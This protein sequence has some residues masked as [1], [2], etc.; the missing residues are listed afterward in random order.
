MLSAEFF[1]KAYSD[2]RLP[3]RSIESKAKLTNYNYNYSEGNIADL[4]SNS[5]ENIQNRLSSSPFQCG[6]SSPTS[7]SLP[8]PSSRQRNKVAAA[9]AALNSSSDK[10][11]RN[12]NQLSPP[13]A[14]IRPNKATI[15]S[16]EQDRDRGDDGLRNLAIIVSEAYRHECVN[17][18][19]RRPLTT[20][21]TTKAAAPAPA[22]TREL[23]H[24]KPL[25]NSRANIAT[26]TNRDDRPKTRGKSKQRSKKRISA[27]NSNFTKDRQNIPTKNHNHRHPGNN[28]QDPRFQKQGTTMSPSETAGV[29]AFARPV[30]RLDRQRL[31]SYNHNKYRQSSAEASSPRGVDEITGRELFIK[32]KRPS[33]PNTIMVGGL[34]IQDQLQLQERCDE[35][36]R[37]NRDLKLMV[38]QLEAQIS[39][40]KNGAKKK[41]NDGNRNSSRDM[42]NNII[43]PTYVVDD[44]SDDDDDDS[45]SSPK[46][47]DD[48]AGIIEECL[49]ASTGAAVASPKKKTIK[50]T[51]TTGRTSSSRKNDKTQLAE[52]KTVVQVLIRDLKISRQNELDMRKK[53]QSAR[54]SLQ[55][56]Q[57]RYEENMRIAMKSADDV[58]ASLLKKLQEEQ[59]SSRNNEATAYS[60]EVKR[61]NR[62]LARA[63]EECAIWKRHAEQQALHSLATAAAAK[64]TSRTQSQGEKGDDEEKKDEEIN[65]EIPKT[66]SSARVGLRRDSDRTR[67]G[68][69]SADQE[70]IP[71]AT[72]NNN[73]ERIAADEEKEYSNHSSVGAQ[74]LPRVE[75]SLQQYNKDTAGK[76]MDF[77]PKPSLGADETERLLDVE[78]PENARDL[79]IELTH[80]NSDSNASKDLSF[81]LG[82]ARDNDTS[83]LSGRRIDFTSCL[84]YTNNDVANDSAAGTPLEYISSATESS[85]SSAAHGSHNSTKSNNK[86][87]LN[88]L[89]KELHA[90]KKRLQTA[91]EKLNTL[92][93]EEGLLVDRVRISEN[94]RVDGSIDVVK[95]LDDGIEV[96]HR[97]F[98][99]V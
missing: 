56:H 54:L 36:T 1:E 68:P 13:M 22:T 67:C 84:E 74:Y 78:K 61:L 33:P 94:S 19:N 93:N 60:V 86:A 4:K 73:F 24:P 55:K 97:S 7:A 70:E 44:D 5:S 76:E 35:A 40:L 3:G 64:T 37:K 57:L 42:H 48:F 9:V 72:P 79:P 23:M 18:E 88:E 82:F 83:H 25:V 81:S 59:Q 10:A 96:S 92:F 95:S 65:A 49:A 12:R 6:R 98:A 41:Q 43:V 45:N 14:A 80:T 85:D 8:V 58:R 15:S 21:P 99:Y 34:T 69:Q 32:Q 47:T 90:S 2:D 39:T 26:N 89:M 77:V 91:D 62:E 52:S 87:T 29:G 28:P 71:P 31:E 50:V 17:A 66:N 11:E 75:V 20:T 16:S 46:L 27:T 51:T 53:L 30:S 38:S 63:K